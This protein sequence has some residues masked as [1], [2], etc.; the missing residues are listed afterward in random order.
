MRA[1]SRYSMSHPARFHSARADAV[2]PDRPDGD[3][4]LYHAGRWCVVFYRHIG[5][6]YDHRHRQYDTNHCRRLQR[7]VQLMRKILLL[8]NLCLIAGPA[9]ADDMTLL[10]VGN[11][12][13]ISS[14]PVPAAAAQYGFTN[15]TFNTTNWSAPY[16]IDINNTREPGFQWY[17]N[18]YYPL[19]SS[20]TFN[21]SGCT[22]GVNCQTPPSNFTI[23]TSTLVIGANDAFSYM[24]T[25]GWNN[26]TSAIIGQSFGSGF[27]AEAQNAFVAPAPGGSASS[28]SFWSEPEEMLAGSVGHTGQTNYVEIGT[29]EAAFG[30]PIND[31]VIDWNDGNSVRNQGLLNLGTAITAYFGA[32]FN[33][34]TLHKYATLWVP[35]PQG[36]GTGYLYTYVDDVLMSTQ[37]Y[38]PTAVASPALSPNNPSGSL[39]EMDTH[40]PCL[41]LQNGVN[42]PMTVGTVRVWQ[43]NKP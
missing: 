26:T 11:Q 32:G 31:H 22:D 5:G 40:H 16:T 13:A 3:W 15:L 29:Q 38:S 7:G 19:A 30:S 10:G 20:P 25:C 39:S 35:S 27:Y 34:N 8:L 4:R 28:P 23:G 14:V 24:S 36:G 2:D 12:P 21:G 42:W 9:A 6:G 1:T 18:L 33:Y 37:T 43:L 41:I 17:V